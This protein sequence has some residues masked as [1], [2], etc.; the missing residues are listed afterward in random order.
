MKLA[1]V[2]L[3]PVLTAVQFALADDF[4]TIDGKEYKNVEVSRVE[5]DG[6]VVTTFSGGIVKIPFNELSPEIKKKYGYNPQTAA[7]YSAEQSEQ[8]AALAQQR[9]ADGGPAVDV[10][11]WPVSSSQI[12][13][14]WT[15]NANNEDRFELQRA[16][17]GSGATPQCGTFVTVQPSLPPNTIGFNDTGLPASHWYCYRV[18]AFNGEGNSSWSN[19]VSVRTH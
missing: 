9:K 16:D 14:Q 5:P 4:K 7:A 2:I 19:S 10:E 18:R 17:G 15:D 1:V 11:G 3:A 8:Q 13:L 12:N 6:I